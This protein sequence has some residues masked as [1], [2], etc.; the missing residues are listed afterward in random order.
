MGEVSG[1]GR[2]APFEAGSKLTGPALR[3][4]RRHSQ[5]SFRRPSGSMCECE[6]HEY[7]VKL[8]RDRNGCRYR[9]NK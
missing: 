4:R 7:E 5:S 3:R 1:Q 2:A 9:I 6:V 8:S